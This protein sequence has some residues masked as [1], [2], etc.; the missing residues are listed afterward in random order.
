MPQRRSTSVNETKRSSQIRRSSGK[1]FFTS[2]SR[3]SCMSRK[4]EEMN[5]R[6]SR[7]VE[8]SSGLMAGNGFA[9]WADGAG[10]GL[11]GA[12]VEEDCGRDAA[13]TG[14]G[15][16]GEDAAGLTDGAS[17]ATQSSA[18]PGGKS[19][20]S[21]GKGALPNIRESMP[22][23]LPDSSA[24]FLIAIMPGWGESFRRSK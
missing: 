7:L 12:V 24:S 15:V 9:G 20:G 17:L 10:D 16:A 8:E 13:A 21:S 23:E 22:R 2:N 19:E 5:T 6:I 18:Q 11:E 1:T 4:V 14:A 3:S